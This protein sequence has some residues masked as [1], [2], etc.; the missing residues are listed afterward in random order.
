MLKRFFDA[1]VVTSEASELLWKSDHHVILDGDPYPLNHTVASTHSGLLC[2][3]LLQQWE[4][5]S[6]L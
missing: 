5:L 6:C 2:H 4:W 1:Y 3:H